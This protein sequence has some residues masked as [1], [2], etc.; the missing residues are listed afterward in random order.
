MRA[1][2]WVIV[3]VDDEVAAFGVAEVVIVEFTVLVN[4]EMGTL[5]RVW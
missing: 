3:L 5:S 1:R 2:D 4:C